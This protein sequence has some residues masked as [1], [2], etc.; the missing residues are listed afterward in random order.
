MFVCNGG[1]LTGSCP[2]PVFKLWQAPIASQPIGHLTQVYV[3]KL[4]TQDEA[5]VLEAASLFLQELQMQPY[6]DLDPWE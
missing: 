2:A 1:D 4:Q 6:H 3:L 5:V